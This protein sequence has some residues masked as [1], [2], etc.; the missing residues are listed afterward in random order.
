MTGRTFPDAVLS[1]I[2]LSLLEG[3]GWYN[4]NY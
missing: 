3:T 2:T 1:V 4:P